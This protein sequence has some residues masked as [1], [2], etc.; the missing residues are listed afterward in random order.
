MAH[1]SEWKKKVLTNR[2]RHV[3]PLSKLQR[4]N[5]DNWFKLKVT[6]MQIKFCFCHFSRLM[7][8]KIKLASITWH[9][10]NSWAD[11]SSASTSKC[12]FAFLDVFP[13]GKTLIFLSF[14]VCLKQRS[15][16]SLSPELVNMFPCTTV[17]K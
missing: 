5:P 6:N 3:M 15:T 7:S 4:S 13:W 1:L 2:Q 9:V 17:S 11:L 8:L 16:K 14:F 10:L 12:C